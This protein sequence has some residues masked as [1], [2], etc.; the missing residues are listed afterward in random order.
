MTSR[1]TRTHDP[2]NR[3]I[4][5]DEMALPS[6]RCEPGKTPRIEHPGGIFVPDITLL[7]S[8][9]AYLV[10]HLLRLIDLAPEGRSVPLEYGCAQ[11]GC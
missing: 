6:H 2:L 5:L 8:D 1:Q 4:W 7:A 3:A 11:Y 9:V 10:L